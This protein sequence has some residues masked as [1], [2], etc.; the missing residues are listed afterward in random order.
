MNEVKEEEEALS[1]RKKAMQS[2]TDCFKHFGS[3]LNS[4]TK[5]IQA[6]KTNLLSQFFTGVKVPLASIQKQL[7]IEKVCEIMLVTMED[8]GGKSTFIER[9]EAAC[10]YVIGGNAIFITDTAAKTSQLLNATRKYFEMIPGAA[11][12]VVK[13]TSHTIE[14]SGKTATG[15]QRGVVTSKH[16]DTNVN[17]VY[18]DDASKIENDVYAEYLEMVGVLVLQI[19]SPPKV[20][21]DFSR[22]CN[23]K[24]RNPAMDVELLE[25]SKQI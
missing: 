23:L 13:S 25:C 10:Q 7:G 2:F 3:S 9:M 6:V 22:M 24:R 17:R 4:Q 19:S 5:A 8:G 15:M 12:L 11:S 20:A 16:M 14:F 1:D 18:I 21:C